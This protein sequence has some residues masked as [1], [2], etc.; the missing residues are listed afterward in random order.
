MQVS[1]RYDLPI[2][3]Y[4]EDRI[5]KILMIVEYDSTVDTRVPRISDH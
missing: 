1:I 5:L 2:F 4:H 3:V